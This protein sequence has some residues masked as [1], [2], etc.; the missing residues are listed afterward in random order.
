MTKEEKLTKQD[1][2]DWAVSRGWTPDKY[3]NLQKKVGDKEYRLRFSSTALR[4]E[5]KV[6]H[7]GTKYSKPSSEWMRLRSG[8]YKELSITPDGRLVGLR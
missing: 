2:I 7:E 5:T 1:I 8:Y 3:G 6:R 4:Y